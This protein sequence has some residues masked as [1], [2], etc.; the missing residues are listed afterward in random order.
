MQDSIKVAA[1]IGNGFTKVAID[2]TRM[3][4]QPSLVA[5]ITD[6]LSNQQQ[7]QDEVFRHLSEQLDINIQSN[8]SLNGRYLIGK[9]AQ[10]KHFG[11]MSFNINSNADKAHSDITLIMTLGMIVLNRLEKLDKRKKLPNQLEINVERLTTALPI[12]EAANRQHCEDLRNRYLNRTHIVTVN[13]FENPIVF[14]INFDNVDVT[15]E[16]VIGNLGLIFEPNT[17]NYR[18]PVFFKD[19]EGTDNKDNKFSGR[20]ILNMGNVIGVD[21][22]DGTIDISVIGKDLEP[23]LGENQYIDG[24]I[25][26][27]I[28]D[29]MQQLRHGGTALNSRQVFLNQALEKNER[30]TY[31]RELLNQQLPVL[32]SQIIEKLKTIYTNLNN[33]IAL[34]Y[35]HGAGA[36]IIKDDFDR[37]LRTVLDE[38]DRFHL[39]KVLWLH[40]KDS[41]WLNLDGLQIQLNQTI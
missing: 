32:E 2:N 23:L 9:A 30:G 29:A 10:N 35:F 38:I 16:G 31:Y 5:H 22:G 26:N 17:L 14:Q 37:K 24:G 34:I 12:I 11:Q 8:L 36:N 3:D 19:L 39:T 28:D 18:K 15:S 40:D 6:P 4:L 21:I 41:Q 1:D 20:D 7:S 25:G 27:V 33:D 13:N